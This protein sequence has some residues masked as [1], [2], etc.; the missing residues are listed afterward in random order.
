[1]SFEQARVAYTR[2]GPPSC[3]LLY[4]PPIT[5]FPR[6]DLPPRAVW[7]KN[8]PGYLD[9]PP[10]GV[11]SGKSKIP[12]PRGN[13]E[14]YGNTNVQANETQL[15]TS[16]A[17]HIGSSSGSGSQSGPTDSAGLLELRIPPRGGR[18][19]ILRALTDISRTYRPIVTFSSPRRA[20]FYVVGV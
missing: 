9:F 16:L 14:I 5:Q 11:I 4:G 7:T 10:G 12:S 6:P 15:T 13:R 2:F 3:V 8:P 20:P 1:M 19:S 17:P 18:P